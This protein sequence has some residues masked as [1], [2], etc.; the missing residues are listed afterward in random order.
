MVP[1]PITIGLR[2]SHWTGWMGA[3]LIK[4]LAEKSGPDEEEIF[5]RVFTASSSGELI[6]SEGKL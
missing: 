6:G 4:T 5:T 2:H 1:F 3:G